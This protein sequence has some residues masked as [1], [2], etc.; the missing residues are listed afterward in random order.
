V[1]GETIR[2]VII[3]TP[4]FFRYGVKT[5]IGH[6][7]NVQ[8]LGI[9]TTGKT[10]FELVAKHLPDLVFIS[11][12]LVELFYLEVVRMILE[13]H[14]KAHVVILFEEETAIHSNDISKFGVSCIPYKQLNLQRLKRF[15]Q[16]HA[17]GD[18]WVTRSVYSESYLTNRYAGILNDRQ[19]N[20]ILLAS[21]GRTMMDIANEVH[22]SVRTVENEFSKINEILGVR[23]K[24]EAIVKFIAN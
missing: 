14:P 16:S 6:L 20:M 21:E 10:G 22:V 15:I 12:D 13:S 23:T 18:F 7:H 9:A 11:T 8:I 3:E 19:I 4:S 24:I 5:L 17:D 2:V 1:V